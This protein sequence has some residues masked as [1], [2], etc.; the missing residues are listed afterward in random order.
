M[1]DVQWRSTKLVLYL[2]I[3]MLEIRYVSMGL[4]WPWLSL[5]LE[6]ELL[7]LDLLLRLYH[8]RIWVRISGWSWDVL[9]NKV[10]YRK[11]IKWIARGPCR[12]IHVSEDIWFKYVHISII[13]AFGCTSSWQIGPR[14]YNSNHHL[15]ETRWWFH[16]IQFQTHRYQSITI[17]HR[18]GICHDR[19]S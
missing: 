6:R 7:M 11:E 13:S 14:R 15:Q 9:T 3:A 12:V 19:R 5:M 4:A 1:Q 18:E 8:E 2:M 16:T 17:H 10:N